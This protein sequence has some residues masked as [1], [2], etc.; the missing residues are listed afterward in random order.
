LKY[1]FN[2]Q[3]EKGKTHLKTKITNHQKLANCH[4]L[5]GNLVN[6]DVMME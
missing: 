5:Q 3:R 1:F 6:D 2:V 4:A